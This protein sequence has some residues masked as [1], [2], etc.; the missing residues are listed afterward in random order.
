[1]TVWG[2]MQ[3]GARYWCQVGLM[4]IMFV[5]SLYELHDD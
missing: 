4:N 2:L 5:M 1:M 3:M